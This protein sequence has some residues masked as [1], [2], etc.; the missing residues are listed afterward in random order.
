MFERFTDRARRVV[1]WAQEE[2][3][4]LGHNHIGSEHLLLGL[5]HEQ[6]GIA[7]QAMT[8]AGIT[9]EAARTAIEELAGSGRE[10]PAG[11]IPFTPRAKKILELSLREALEQQKSYIG[12]EH[13]LLGLIRDANG[14]GAQVLVRL[15][16]PL[17]ALRQRVIDAA[18]SS[19]PDPAAGRE[20]EHEMWTVRRAQGFMQTIRPQSIPEAGGL[21]APVDRRLASIERHLGITPEDEA[22]AGFTRLLASIGQRLT[23]IE[24]HLGITAGEEAGEPGP[25]AEE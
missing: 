15:G 4:M 13:V 20:T 24:R 12:T 25:T 11:P 17:P 9:A 22:V 21:I 10:S 2:A 3:R 16:E 8:A 6:G 18:A 1:V 5:L 7:A 14:A 23:S 19:A